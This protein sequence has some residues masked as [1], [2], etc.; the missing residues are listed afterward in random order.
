MLVA[1][2]GFEPVTSEVAGSNPVD[3][4]ITRN[5]GNL[6]PPSMDGFK[7]LAGHICVSI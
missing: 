7:F 4:A 6:K 2:Q 5:S 3:S 1:R